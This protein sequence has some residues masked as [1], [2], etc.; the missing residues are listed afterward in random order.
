[1]KSLEAAYAGDDSWA[2]TRD[3]VGGG[4]YGFYGFRAIWAFWAL[5]IRGSCLGYM[6]VL[7]FTD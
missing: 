5:R 7:G 1:M 2:A 3:F 4:V 6:G